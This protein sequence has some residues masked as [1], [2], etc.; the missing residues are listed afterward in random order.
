MTLAPPP[1][2]FADTV[3][4][5]LVVSCATAADPVGSARSAAYLKDVAP[6]LG[7]PAPPTPRAHTAVRA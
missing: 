2:A 4:A 5:R 1:S 7:I 3:P 6:F